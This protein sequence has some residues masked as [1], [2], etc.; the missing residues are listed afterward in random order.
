MFLLRFLPSFFMTIGDHKAGEYLRLEGR[1]NYFE[2]ASLN[3]VTI[4]LCVSLLYWGISTPATQE[5]SLTQAIIV[6]FGIAIPIK[7]INNIRSAR[8][9]NY[10]NDRVIFSDEGIILTRHSGLD[11]TT[12]IK[13]EQIKRLIIVEELIRFKFILNNNP[14][15]LLEINSS[16]EIR[17]QIPEFHKDIASILGLKVDSYFSAGEEEKVCSMISEKADES[18]NNRSYRPK[19]FSIEKKGNDLIFRTALSSSKGSFSISLDRKFFWLVRGL[20]GSVSYKFSEISQFKIKIYG[21]TTDE[22]MVTGRLSFLDSDGYRVEALRINVRNKPIKAIALL[23]LR[24]DLLF[25]A[26]KMNEYVA[27]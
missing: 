25:L 26:G 11:G 15:P 8:G 3:I 7:C 21:S 17:D 13:V 4:L 1:N 27:D 20:T 12:T 19:H 10:L 18:E 16:Q 22:N 9:R 14:K 23:E 6:F 5:S 2:M 24:E